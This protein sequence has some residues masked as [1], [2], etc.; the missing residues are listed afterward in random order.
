MDQIDTLEQ[1]LPPALETE[2]RT[3]TPAQRKA[4]E[5]VVHRV[6]AARDSHQVYL[7]TRSFGERLSDGLA[8]VGGSWSFIIAFVL[9][10][11]G[12]AV[13]N[14]EILG[15]RK[16]AFDPYPYVFLNLL[17]SMLAALQAPVIMMAQNRQTEAD[18]LA[19]A[20]DY[21]VNLKA[22]FEIQRLH[23][24]MDELRERRWSELVAQQQ[25]QIRLLQALLER[26]GT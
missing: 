9:F 3:F 17:L 16:E 5:D 4:I 7:E 2:W 8:R 25:E 20:G 12:W 6:R 13:L 24:K 14:T 15:P 19:A 23:D 22:E 11:G 21:Q 26:Q 1:P 10:L 18:R